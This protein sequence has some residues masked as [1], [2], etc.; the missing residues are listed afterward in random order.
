MCMIIKGEMQPTEED[1]IVDCQALVADVI[2]AAQFCLDNDFNKVEV[3]QNYKLLKGNILGLLVLLI[4]R[5]R[6][7]GG[8]GS[9]R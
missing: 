2:S 4:V 5:L 8:F 3:L 1:M 7:V 9:Q 6:T